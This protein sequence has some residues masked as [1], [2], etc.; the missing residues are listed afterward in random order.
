MAPSSPSHVLHGAGRGAGGAEEQGR[1]GRGLRCVR[2]VQR[3]GR[4]LSCVRQV[5]RAGRGLR[6]VRQVQ[7]AG[8][9]VSGARR[10]AVDTEYVSVDIKA[11]ADPVPH[12]VAR[13]A[14]P[15][16]P[17]SPMDD[18]QWLDHAAAECGQA[19]KGQEGELE[20]HVGPHTQ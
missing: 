2:Q 11:G 15:P 7:R 13:P 14:A 3:A 4:G 8:A 1:A 18:S 6:Y 12:R 19:V 5:Q 17:P 10:P 16:Q 20:G 9:C